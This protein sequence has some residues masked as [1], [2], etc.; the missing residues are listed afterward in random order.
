M[1]ARSMNPA[2]ASRAVVAGLALA[3][4]SG[5]AAWQRD[6]ITVGAV[7]DDYRTNHPIVVSEKMR[8]ID[9]PVGASQHAMADTQAIAV[10]GF[11]DDYDRSSRPVVTIMVPHGSANQHAAAIVAGQ[12]RGVI[13]QEGVGD[14]HILQQAY[15]ADGAAEAPIRVRYA[16]LTAST[17]PCGRWDADL[18]DN[19]DNRHYTNF[20]CASQNNL[21]AQIAAPS[22]LLGP[23]RRTPID[24]ENRGNAIDQ[25][26]RRAVA[27]DVRGNREVSY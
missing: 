8:S 14:G 17:G 27:A 13:R 26:Q 6:S 19:P 16:A 15:V 4:L 7:P 11:L 10:R 21:A 1:S 23:R 5:C 18:L 20:G 3:L 9:I 2:M 25:Y 22:D 24:A 12:L